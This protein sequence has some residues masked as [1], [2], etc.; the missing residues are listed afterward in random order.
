MNAITST[1]RRLS[2]TNPAKRLSRRRAPRLES[3]EIRTLYSAALA[4]ASA[5]AAA[6]AAAA[7]L[8][9]SGT[10]D[11]GSFRLASQRVVRGSVGL[12]SSDAL[13][14]V[15]V[16]NPIDLRVTLSGLLQ[17]DQVDLL[18]SDGTSVGSTHF[19]AGRPTLAFSQRLDPGTYFIDV[20]HGLIDP[21]ATAAAAAALTPATR[22]ITYH[23]RK[24]D[25]FAM[26][27]RGLKADRT[28]PPQAPTH[29]SGFAAAFSASNRS[30][31]EPSISSDLANS[32]G[33]A[34]FQDF[35]ADPLW[36]S[37]GPS[38]DDVLQ[39]GLGDCYFLSVLSGIARSDPGLIE[40]SIV[41]QANGEY[42][43][44]FQNGGQEFDQQVDASL[45]VDGSGNPVFARIAGDNAIWPALMEKA[46]CYY[47]GLQSPGSYD[48]AQGFGQGGL[49][50]LSMG[51]LGSTD[52]AETSV[53][54]FRTA[55][56]FLSTVSSDLAAGDIVDLDTMS[57]S[58]TGNSRLKSGLFSSHAYSVVAADPSSNTIQLRNP[59]GTQTEGTLDDGSGGYVTISGDAALQ[60]MTAISQGTVPQVALNPNPTPPPPPNPMPN[61]SN[62][63]DIEGELGVNS[64]QFSDGSNVDV[65]TFTANSAGQVEVAADST[66]FPA[67]LLVAEVGPDGQLFL[68]GSARSTGG[69]AFADVTF[70]ADAQ[71][72]YEIGV[73]SANGAVS[74]PYTLAVAGDVSAPQQLTPFASSAS[75]SGVVYEDLNGNGT[76][77]NNEPG[78]QGWTVY[79]DLGDQGTFVSGDPF[80]TT[81][82][83]GAYA[84]TGL[85]SGTYVVRVIPQSGWNQSAPQGNGTGWQ[86]TATAGQDTTVNAF[87]EV[88]V[89]SGTL[90]GTVY[91]DLN[92]D[93]VQEANEPG[94]AGWIVYLDLT[95][96]GSYLSGDPY[97]VT[98]ASGNYTFS[99]LPPGNYVVRL[100]H[101]YG[102]TTTQGSN[103]WNTTLGVGETHWGGSFGEV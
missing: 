46:F 34:Q 4:G 21:L 56:Q 78:L 59:W 45:P 36:G 44:K 76:R 86:L 10:T 27:V 3:L 63:Q 71:A 96:Y 85:A 67:E 5:A 20:S 37:S 99:G 83:N 23:F 47:P 102:W 17:A 12:A 61:P 68:I 103:D 6:A 31:L 18:F 58:G 25:P 81:D 97:A 89:A 74:G 38:P 9:L 42:L 69:A 66:A 41:P 62:E 16:T 2:A 84:F 48:A 52:A 32:S 49:P 51:A 95:N 92:A 11:L 53:A 91:H 64:F 93:G 72:Q 73:W 100:I 33:F 39:T 13:Y 26:A 80:T 24:T 82:P 8:G 54:S 22:T 70:T 60:S 57:Q 19:S 30:S 79:I 98:D 15:T 75:L 65:Y 29:P 94:L 14:K 50:S 87:G 101:V 77:Q 88:P 28:T 7:G 40:Q 90:F 43:V 55:A 35:S 1:K